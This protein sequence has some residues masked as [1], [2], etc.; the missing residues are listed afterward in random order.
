M[1]ANT[2]TCSSTYFRDVLCPCENHCLFLKLFCHFF[3]ACGFIT[4]SSCPLFAGVTFEDMRHLLY[5]YLRLPAS[6]HFPE[7]QEKTNI[8]EADDMMPSLIVTQLVNR[9]EVFLEEHQTSRS[10]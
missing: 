5:V 9:I 4:Y 8:C 3:F 7:A 1:S 6:F 2:C 10:V